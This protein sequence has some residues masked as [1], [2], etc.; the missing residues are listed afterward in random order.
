MGVWSYFSK[1]QQN[2]EQHLVETFKCPQPVIKMSACMKTT[3]EIQIFRL[4][5]GFSITSMALCIHY[6]CADILSDNYFTQLVKQIGGSLKIQKY[7]RFQ[8]NWAPHIFGPSLPIFGKFG[9][10]KMLVWQIGPRQ[11]GPK[12]IWPL[13]HKYICIGIGYT[14]ND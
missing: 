6:K 14:A 5:N 13:Y 3:L 11:I 9:P 8:A 10:L 12:Q 2:Q 7:D 4:K 1:A